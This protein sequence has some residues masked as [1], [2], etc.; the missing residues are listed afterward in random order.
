MRPSPLSF[1]VLAPV[2]LTRWIESTVGEVDADGDEPDATVDGGRYA[3]TSA[4]AAGSGSAAAWSSS[5]GVGS[6]CT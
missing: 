4:S 1:L 3:S 2:F 5:R 6:M